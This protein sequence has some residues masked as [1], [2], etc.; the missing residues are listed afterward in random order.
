MLYLWGIL[1]RGDCFYR[2]D[3]RGR[4][5]LQN[6]DFNIVQIILKL[7]NQFYISLKFSMQLLQ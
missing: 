5:K 4:K 3:R 1:N 2:G 7:I 6:I